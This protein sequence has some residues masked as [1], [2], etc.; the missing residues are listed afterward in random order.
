MLHKIFLN[1]R[2]LIKKQTI[3]NKIR[4]M[5]LRFIN[6]I[7][8][9]LLTTY[10]III[11]FKTKE[12]N[13]T[14]YRL[15]LLAEL[16]SDYEAETL[17][18]QFQQQLITKFYGL[19]YYKKEVKSSFEREQIE[20]NFNDKFTNHVS[21]RF[22]CRQWVETFRETPPFGFKTIRVIDETIP[23]NDVKD[24]RVNILKSGDIPFEKYQQLFCVEIDTTDF[25]NFKPYR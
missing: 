11:D 9:S 6:S 23:V 13:P 3:T 19:N 2:Q 22:I 24:Y 10:H 18:N 5:I 12:D 15:E 25:N 16:R 8:D 14:F 20:K 1:L 7:Q 4:K 21:M 17:I